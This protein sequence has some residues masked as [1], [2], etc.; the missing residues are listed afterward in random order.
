[1]RY[2]H[3]IQA[4]ERFLASGCYR[5]G[6]NGQTLAK[7]ESWTMHAHSDGE[8]FVRVDMD[9][10]QEE[11]KSILAEALLDFKGALVRFDI[12]YENDQFKGGIKRLRATYQRADERL[13]IGYS[14]N[15][16]ERNYVEVALPAD[17]LIDLPLLV[18][19]GATIRALAEKPAGLISVYVPMIEHPQLFPGILRQVT[20]PVERV[21]DDTVFIG[22][23]AIQA[24][25]FRYRDK[26]VSYWIDDHDLIVKRVNSYKQQEMTVA[27]SNYA[28]PATKA[29]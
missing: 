8:K 6:K 18:F 25:R 1:M 13:Q 11:G 21:G 22:K 15:G 7:T 24:S 12:R 2:L 16:D 10:R 14:L 5:F 26:A 3:A 17:A 23:R 4:H 9:A 28:A 27:I 20:S 19:R 29:L